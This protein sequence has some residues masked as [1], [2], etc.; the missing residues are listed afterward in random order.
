MN[1]AKHRQKEIKKSQEEPEDEGMVTAWIGYFFGAY[2][3]QCCGNRDTARDAEL[4]KQAAE[5]GRPPPKPKKATPQPFPGP[6]QEAV[7]SSEP[8]EDRRRKARE[9][10]ERLRRQRE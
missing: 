10:E 3:T 1:L 5:T 2:G 8:S 6:P 7:P 4:A 9:E